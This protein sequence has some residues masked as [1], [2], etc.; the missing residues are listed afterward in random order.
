MN[1]EI[2]HHRVFFFLLSRNEVEEEEKIDKFFVGETRITN[3]DENV[4]NWMNDLFASDER[5]LTDECQ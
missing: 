1:C 3:D 5:R 4:E 2:N